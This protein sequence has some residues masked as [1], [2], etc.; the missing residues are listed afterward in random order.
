MFG[1]DAVLAPARRACS[2]DGHQA[3][4]P[5]FRLHLPQVRLLIHETRL[6]LPVRSGVASPRKRKLRQ[7]ARR[8]STVNENLRIA[9]VNITYAQS[10][11]TKATP[12]ASPRNH[13]P[14]DGY[15]AQS[16]IPNP[17]VITLSKTVQ[18]P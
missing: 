12:T 7:A 11:R 1:I 6:R 10:R 16:I 18:P 8:T 17:T 3:P 15:S 14:D 2:K 5:R 4:S 9:V 13:L